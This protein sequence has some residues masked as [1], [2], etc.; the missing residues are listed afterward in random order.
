MGPAP[1]AAVR[2]RGKAQAHRGVIGRRNVLAVRVEDPFRQ[3]G[4]AARIEREEDL[5][6]AVV[7]LARVPLGIRRVNPGCP[8]AL[9][10]QIP[11]AAT[12]PGIPWLAHGRALGLLGAVGAFGQHRALEPPYALDRHPRR[13]G[14][15]LGGL[16]GANPVLDLLGSQGTLHFNLVLRKPREL[17]AGHYPQPVIDPQREAA[18]AP[19]RGENGIST[20]LTDRD[21][22]QLLHWR[23]FCAAGR[24][25]AH[26]AARRR[27][28]DL[29]QVSLT[30]QRA[31][32]QHR[33]R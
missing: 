30:A 11:E 18:T 27:S 14:D 4:T 21:E 10:Y 16:P 28:S 1:A 6:S 33:D 15:L 5:P 12:R 17:P 26:G 23:P 7:A 3:V 29:P 31:G 2:R 20:V 8:Q 19:R 9:L 24:P 25:G 32:G 22:A 13:I